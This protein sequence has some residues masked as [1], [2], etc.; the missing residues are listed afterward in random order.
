MSKP[1]FPIAHGALIDAATKA[2]AS[3]SSLAANTKGIEC[4][5]LEEHLKSYAKVWEANSR[6]SKLLDDFMDRARAQSGAYVSEAVLKQTIETFREN[7]IQALKVIE[8]CKALSPDQLKKKFTD[9]FALKNPT[10]ENLD[11]LIMIKEVSTELAVNDPKTQGTGDVA[12]NVLHGQL[13]FVNKKDEAIAAS[14]TE[15]ILPENKKE[16][17]LLWAYADLNGNNKASVNELYTLVKSKFPSY[18]VPRIIRMAYVAAAVHG[19]DADGWLDAVEFA[20]FLKN[21]IFYR[22]TWVLFQ[23]MDR[24]GD[25]SVSQ[26]EFLQSVQ[27][28][29]MDLG[30]D[31]GVNWVEEFKKTAGAN[32]QMSY[33]ELCHWIADKSV[34]AGTR[35]KKGRPKSGKKKKITDG[36][37]EAV[38]QVFVRPASQTVVTKGVNSRTYTEHETDILDLARN[39]DREEERKDLWDQIN[40][41]NPE[42]AAM[43]D[44]VK[45]CRSNWASGFSSGFT[46]G[47][48]EYQA[49]KAAFT[50]ASSHSTGNGDG[51]LEYQ[52]LPDF[53]ENLVH[54]HALYSMFCAIDNDGDRRIDVYEFCRNIGTLGFEI[55][56]TNFSK[57]FL[58]ID[59]DGG[60]TIEFS[61]FCE[62]ANHIYKK[63][64]AKDGRDELG[65]I[66]AKK[67]MFNLTLDTPGAADGSFPSDSVALHGLGGKSY[68]AGA[69]MGV[70]MDDMIIANFVIDK[71]GVP[72]RGKGQGDTAAPRLFAATYAGSVYM[73]DISGAKQFKTE[74]G[75]TGAAAAA[76]APTDP[77]RHQDFPSSNFLAQLPHQ[78][79]YSRPRRI[80]ITSLA[81][82]NKQGYLAVGGD[83][84]TVGI[85]DVRSSD[86]SN[87]ECVKLWSST[88]TQR[89]SSMLF[90]EQQ[91]LL[92][93]IGYDGLFHAR[94][95]E[96]DKIVMSYEFPSQLGAMVEDLNDHSL[97]IGSWDG[98]VQRLDLRTKT[99]VQQ[100]VVNSVLESPVRALCFAQ[101]PVSLDPPKKRKDDE[102][103]QERNPCA[104]LFAAHG[105]GNV[106]CWDYRM[107]GE[108]TL[109][110]PN[111]FGN[112]DM[113]NCLCVV[114]DMLY[115]ASDA[116][117]V[118]IF[119]VARDTHLE[120]LVGHQA[121]I[122]KMM[123][124]GGLLFTGSFDR[125]V[126]VYDIPVIEHHITVSA[127]KREEEKKERYDKWLAQKQKENG[128]KGSKKGSKKGKKGKGGKKGSKKGKGKKKK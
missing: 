107:G 114:N 62:W 9:L 14:I 21:L 121:G 99:A 84:G 11:M 1:K 75:G 7:V 23:D 82:H 27:S 58:G 79:R 112:T 123:E 78:G 22:K 126:R 6:D 124:Y 59:A 93:S 31:E 86:M 127:L 77:T 39:P 35:V 125:T 54:Y 120:T 72:M 8:D 118:Q 13:K 10:R 97:L 96:H 115:T 53:L 76:A 60:G 26:R 87:P 100:F 109:L 12:R 74:A 45:M 4:G 81:L 51:W 101:L 41:K 46:S 48:S 111:Y 37:D 29:D 63:K 105:S 17:Q 16:L 44:L 68:T 116:G 49:V 92:Y 103:E 3:F 19:G 36:E 119:D 25:G 94:H 80:P 15:I 73:W 85:W 89:V 113:V 56:R 106:M 71:H 98:H 66:N 20:D 57:E 34:L 110:K 47:F 43:N 108:G 50:D 117:T 104:L 18:A 38:G 65:G 32:A 95:V 128:K 55:D 52:E 61:E 102:V 70:G 88:H 91:G 5:K 90:D 64:D 83:D 33:F 122:T 67:T 24:D 69:A 28:L 30:T 2:L 42:C 40:C